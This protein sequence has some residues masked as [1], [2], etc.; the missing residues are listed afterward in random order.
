[1]DF[2]LIST[3]LVSAFFILLIYIKIS[4]R[5]QLA[6][7]SPSDEISNMVI[8]ALIGT[9][10]ISTELSVIESMAI[11]AIWAFLN[12]FIRY[13][14]YKSG[15]ITEIIDGKRYELMIDGIINKDGFSKAKLSMIDFQN[16][17]H[18][19]G[20]KSISEVKNAWF[21]P[22]GNI[23]IDLKDE[24]SQSKVL[25]YDDNYNYSALED[26]D[27]TKEQLDKI[28]EVEGYTNITEIFCVEYYKNELYVYSKEGTKKIKR[29]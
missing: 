20:V 22:S 23:T 27:I 10:V 16:S 28:L 25:I 2:K 24:T 1:M 9:V 3:K 8:G 14:K 5:K 11:V 12:I 21:D 26:M 15:V 18:A 7:L 29:D 6:P 4:G 13:L 17:I 19:Q